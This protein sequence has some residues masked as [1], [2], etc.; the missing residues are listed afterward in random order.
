MRVIFYLLLVKTVY[1]GTKVTVGILTQEISPTL[2]KCIRQDAKHT[3]DY[4]AFIVSSYVKFVESSGARVIPIKLD[5]NEPY[6]EH[7]I[8]NVS[9]LLIPGGVSKLETGSFYEALKVLYKII[10]RK[11][12]A[13]DYFPILGICLGM[14]GLV[15]V[16]NKNVNIRKHCRAEN[17]LLDIN[18][19][20]SKNSKMFKNIETIKND[21][22]KVAPH[23]HNYCILKEDLSQRNWLVTSENFDEEDNLFVASLEH[24]KYPFYGLQFHPEK[25]AFEWKN[26][27]NLN[28]S[29]SGIRASRYFG[30]FFIE[31]CRKNDNVLQDNKFLFINRY[32]QIPT[33]KYGCAF[34]SVYVFE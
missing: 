1:A 8:G 12:E 5:K 17:I 34:D 24:K 4:T 28:K 21:L 25:N 29:P 16:A 11:N 7:I 26:D 14:E 2:Q 15:M 6:Y 27:L 22:K 20:S 30:D 19:T 18:V 32:D 13:G 10:V 3:D 31:E 23:F 9:G 33:G